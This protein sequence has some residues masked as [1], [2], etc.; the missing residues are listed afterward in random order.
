MSKRRLT[1]IAAA[2][3]AAATLLSASPWSPGYAAPSEPQVVDNFRLVDQNGFAREL[4]R[5]QDA[6]AVVLAMHVAD[7]ESSRR[8]AAKLAALKQEFPGVEFMMLNSSLDDA[9][10]DIEADAKAASIALP[11]LD[12]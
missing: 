9:R 8:A 1:H 7:N 4:Y 5:L 12:D 3:A 10:G 6:K 2:A 11:V